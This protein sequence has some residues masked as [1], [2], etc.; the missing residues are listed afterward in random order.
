MRLDVW[1]RA[2][3]RLE[4]GVHYPLT[5]EVVNAQQDAADLAYRERVIP[6]QVDVR[7]AIVDIRQ[8]ESP[9]TPLDFHS[10]ILS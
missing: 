1:S 6:R 5:D 4:W 7:D 9:T 10:Q 3:P 2:L 8:D